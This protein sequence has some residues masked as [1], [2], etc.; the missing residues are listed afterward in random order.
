MATDDAPPPPE[1]MTAREM[2]TQF[3][4]IPLFLA[5][6]CSAIFLGIKWM[7][8]QDRSPEAFAQDLRSPDRRTRWIA[9]LEATQRDLKDPALAPVLI[10]LLG[11]PAVDR[12]T[13]WSPM[14]ALKPA[15]E[16][17]MEIRWFAAQALGRLGDPRA[18]EPLRKALSDS[19]GGVRLF[20]ALALGEL[21]AHAAAEDL[22]ALLREDPDAGA[23]K[24]AAFALGFLGGEVAFSA[25]KRGLL[26]VEP[27]VRWNAALALAR[28]KNEAAVPTLAE[29][30]DRARVAAVQVPAEG[31]GMR[32]LSED[33]IQRLLSAAIHAGAV[34]AP[35]ALAEPIRRL[36]EDP[37]LAV[38]TLATRVRIA[39]EKENR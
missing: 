31:G 34:L 17:R 2:L 33:E 5:G 6:I 3:I 38:Q 30:L 21:G 15:G 36:E 37:N 28:L 8:A 20:S 9:A 27:Q 19:N 24:A 12:E 13:A 1:R 25:L 18:I 4:L 39:R 32:P 11:E 29:M 26:D 16:H 7:T 14:D 35:E 10:D 23:R 22:A